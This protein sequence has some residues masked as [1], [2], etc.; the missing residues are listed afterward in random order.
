MVMAIQKLLLNWFSYIAEQPFCWSDMLSDH[1]SK[2]IILFGLATASKVLCSVCKLFFDH[3]CPIYC[4]WGY[5]VRK[6]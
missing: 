4:T 2:I 5:K 3:T 1:F 6:S